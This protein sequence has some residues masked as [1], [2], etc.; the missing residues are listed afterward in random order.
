MVQSKPYKWIQFDNQYTDLC[1]Q[2]LEK[3]ENINVSAMTSF[4]SYQRQFFP[5]KKPM[6]ILFDGTQEE[7]VGMIIYSVNG[8]CLAVFSEKFKLEILNQAFDE[9]FKQSNQR[10]F[11]LLGP[12]ATIDAMIHPI[13]HARKKAVHFRVE[14]KTLC[15]DQDYGLSNIKI[16]TNEKLKENFVLKRL[17][18]S[19]LEKILDLQIAYEKEEV[20]IPGHRLNPGFTEKQLRQALKIQ[21]MYGLFYKKT[22]VSKVSTNSLGHNFDQIGG[23]YTKPEFR[24]KGLASYLMYYLIEDIFSRNKGLSLFV[25]T[26]NASALALYDKLGFREFGPFSIAYYS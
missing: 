19:D 20:L 17:F 13:L 2:F 7:I 1:F 15:L 25:K 5:R 9:L 4:L 22:L 26:K 3:N 12:K 10:F 8:S 21:H 23:V 11:S 24:N 14:Y 18:V 6:Y 16:K